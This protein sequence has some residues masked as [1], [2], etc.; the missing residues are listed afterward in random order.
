MDSINP[1]KT[2]RNALVNA[3]GRYAYNFFL[4]ALADLYENTPNPDDFPYSDEKGFEVF[5]H[6]VA[7]EAPKGKKRP[8]TIMRST[9]PRPCGP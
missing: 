3:A 9:P 2:Q 6:L 1:D 7:K 5:D 8:I 4:A